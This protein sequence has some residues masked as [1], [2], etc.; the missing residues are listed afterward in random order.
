M[1]NRRLLCSLLVGAGLISSFGLAAAQTASGPFPNRPIRIIVPFVPGG[2]IDVVT[3]LLARN[4]QE[5]LKQPVV[6]DN[7][8]GAGGV[9]G[10]DHVAKSRPDGYT[11]VLNAATPMVTVVSLSSAPYDIF[12]TSPQWRESPPSTMCS[13]SMP[14][15]VS[16]RCRIWCSWRV[17]TPA[18]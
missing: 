12:A 8:A 6:V 18:N 9:V 4:L 11:L 16:S 14:S 7:R 13:R 3:R 17:K 1:L 5:S 15:R 2:T 10:V